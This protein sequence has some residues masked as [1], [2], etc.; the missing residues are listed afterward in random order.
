[1]WILKP[2]SRRWVIPTI[3]VIAG[4]VFLA[5]LGF[6]QLDRLEQRRAFNVQVANQWR[7]EPFDVNRNELPAELSDLEYRRVVATGA[8]DY[9]RQV[10][11]SNQ[12][13]SGSPGVVLVTPLVLDDGRAV[14]VA[15]GWVPFAQS[16]PE[17]WPQYEEPAGAPVVGLLQESQLLPSGEAPPVPPEPQQEWYQINVDAIQAQMPYELLPVF[18]L[19]L[20]EEGRPY[21]AL[22][23]REEPL[24]LT[25]GNHLSYAVQWFTFAAILGF[26]YLQFIRYHERREQRLKEAEQAG[27]L[28]S[29]EILDGL[30]QPKGHA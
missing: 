22:P 14:L 13:R 8:F 19:Q 15:R 12:T 2:F 1:M 26:G 29:Q 7:Q 18:I 16:T 5:R 3:L 11:L 17:F 20:P 24:Q 9:G 30:P 25:E 6:W 21:D 10:V 28:E 4:M 23:F 27:M